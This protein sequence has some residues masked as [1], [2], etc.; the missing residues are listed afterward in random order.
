[1]DSLAFGLL[2]HSDDNIYWTKEYSAKIINKIYNKD[3]NSYK[4]TLYFH[5][6]TKMY[7]YTSSYLLLKKRC[8]KENTSKGELFFY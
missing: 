1:M 8:N 5:S 2:I 4:Y 6:G 3:T 7:N